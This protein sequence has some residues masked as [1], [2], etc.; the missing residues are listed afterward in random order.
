MTTLHSKQANKDDSIKEN[1]KEETHKA[2]E[3][4]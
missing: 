1:N 3:N 2:K 4:V